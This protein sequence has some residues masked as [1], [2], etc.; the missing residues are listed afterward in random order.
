MDESGLRIERTRTG[1]RAL[2]P[3]LRRRHD[4]DIALPLRSADDLFET[5]EV[6]PFSADFERYGDRPGVETI[7]GVLR[8]ERPVGHVRTVVQLSP[9]T[10]DSSAEPRTVDA[11]R[12]YCRVK[13]AD[14][15]QE[16]REIRRYGSWALVLGFVAVLLLNG[17][18]RTL[19]S[20]DDNTLQ[21]ISQGLQVASWVTLWFPI[22][23]L[24]YDRWYARRDQ[25]IYRQMLEMDLSVVVDAERPASG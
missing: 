1:R 17:I 5:P 25:A 15:D 12:R 23:L 10:V 2:W 8:V 22:N 7:A 13:T 9:G 4:V 14:L 18:A 16:L 20:S 11:V 19:D 6:D 3:P 24:V 21:A